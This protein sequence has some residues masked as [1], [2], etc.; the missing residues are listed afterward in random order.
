MILLITGTPGT[1]KTTVSRLLAELLSG[2]L[3]DLNK[4][5]EQ[6]HLYTG[7]H[8]E[9]GFKIVDMKKM[10]NRI[11]EIIK[12]LKEDLIIIEGHL[13]HFC[14]EAD[15]VVVLRSHPS[16]LRKRLQDKGFNEFKIN[17]N[18]EAEALDICVFEAFQIHSDKVNEIDT[19]NKSPQDV[20][21]L[22]IRVIN[23]EE[24]F[25]AGEADFLDYL[26]PSE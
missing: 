13:S 11:S 17:E 6:E 22:I 10:C 19:S 14:E 16:F 18:I 4:L 1:G 2:H 8:P 26:H 23:G 7:Y 21:D 15:L 9:Y 25:P 12:N 24:H 5:I 3:I 20:V